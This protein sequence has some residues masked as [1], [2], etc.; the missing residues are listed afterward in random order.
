MNL[1]KTIY[2]I[3]II[4]LFAAN[5]IADTIYFKNGSRLDIENVWEEDGKIK[6]IMFGN[7]YEYRKENIDRI[8]RDG[9]VKRNENSVQ[10]NHNTSVKKQK[11]NDINNSNIELSFVYHKE[12][13]E[14]SVNENWAK[15]IEKEKQ[16]YLLNPKEKEI[17]NSLTYFY[18]MYAI[19]LYAK[20][21]MKTAMKY[22]HKALK[23]KSD[24]PPAKE[25]IS[26]VYVSY[27]QGSYD[28]RDYD[29]A[30]INLREATRYY[31][32]NA[33]IYV[34]YGKIAYDK[35]QFNE[36][37]KEWSR[38]LDINPNL[39][40]VKALLRKFSQE[41]RVEAKFEKSNTGNFSIKFEGDEKK[42][43]A[44]AAI[45]ILNEAYLDVGGNLFEYPKHTIEVIIYPK[46]DIKELDYYPDMAAGLYDG[47]IRFSE[48]LYR[49]KEFFK[50]VLYHEYTHVI[51]HIKGGRNVPIWLN[52]GLAE[53]SARKFKPIK[54][55][56]SRESILKSAA[57]N[58]VIIPF[59]KLSITSLAGLKRLSYPVIALLYAQSDSFVTYIIDR[60]TIY[61]VR[62]ILE[63]LAKG[64]SIE[65]AIMDTLNYTIED[66][67][68]EWKNTLPK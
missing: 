6:C 21:Y 47:K 57:S 58:N 36:A 13:L 33:D 48:G 29:K 66:L 25:G 54:H 3:I 26:K 49:D 35:D 10:S 62:T 17:Q 67:E 37:K 63:A 45:E 65:K 41:H 18:T 46:S 11:S 8:E 38:A 31:P 44:D 22:C 19:K 40:E 27:A 64:D 9:K 2:L 39:V 12:A 28:Q 7:T 43:I 50:A 4:G 61:D 32:E 1:K 55:I 60:F 56:T 5:G 16:A 53:Y 68:A 52:E 34:L 23:I 15:A 20:G 24:Y 42:E 30:E 51:V 59:K 14:H